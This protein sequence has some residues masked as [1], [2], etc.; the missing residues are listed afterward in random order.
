MNKKIVIGSRGSKLALIYAQTA[1]NKIV[2]NTDLN[3]EDIIIKEIT[4]KGDQVQD[5]RLSEVGGKGLFSTNIENELQDKKIDIAVHALKDMPANETN[6]LRTNTFLERNDPREI[7]ITKDKKKLKDLQVEAIIGTSSYRREF[8]IKK[9][10]SD[11]KCKLIRGNV[12]T[13]IK[14]LN[15][16]LYDAIILSYAGIKSLSIEDKITEIFSTQE[17]IPSAG[18]GIISLQCRNDNK[19][20]ISILDSIN[21]QKTY[22]RAHAERNVLKVLEGDCETA[23]GA[24]SIIEGD[25]IVLEAELFSLDGKQ[26]FYEKKSSKIENAKSLGEEVGKILKVKSNNSYKK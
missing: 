10:R 12:D 4:T 8:Q 3:D 20:I 23:I 6:G 25:K 2:Q 21:D 16:G 22:L 18:Q 24:H 7:L 5:K 11:L 13:R 9:I 1:K 19:D 14:K 15:D 26:R 17:V